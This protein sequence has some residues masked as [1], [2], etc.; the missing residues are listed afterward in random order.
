MTSGVKTRHALDFDVK[1]AS[2]H[3]LR[4]HELTVP[5]Y[6]LELDMVLMSADA[7]HIVRFQGLDL[8]VRLYRPEPPWPVKGFV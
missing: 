8:V 7:V 5:R 6:P 2:T 4:P 3:S 1:C